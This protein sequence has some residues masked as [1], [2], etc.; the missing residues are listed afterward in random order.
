MYIGTKLRILWYT[1][2]SLKP[3][4]GFLVMMGG[5]LGLMGYLHQ[6][7]QMD[8]ASWAIFRW[9]GGG[10]IVGVLLP[11]FGGYV[12][13]L[14]SLRRA[15]KADQLDALCEDFEDA[16]PIAHGYARLGAHYFFGKGGRC[17]VPYEDVR[18]VTLHEH[19]AGLQR[20][21]RKL[22][23]VDARGKE[24]PLCGLPLFGRR[25]EEIAYEVQSALGEKLR[26]L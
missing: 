24:H 11:Y 21:Q 16:Q 23:Y 20:N 25:G 10:I 13:T 6:I 14:R 7:S 9:V 18:R 5:F 12:G 19:Y 22:R 26:S 2:P 17:V 8:E 3:Y 1:R 15:G 4:L